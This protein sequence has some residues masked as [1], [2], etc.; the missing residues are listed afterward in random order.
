M[1]EGGVLQAAVG[2]DGRKLGRDRLLADRGVPVPAGDDALH[3]GAARR[4]R[5]LAGAEQDRQPHVL[6]PFVLPGEQLGHPGRRVPDVHPAPRP[7]SHQHKLAGQFGPVEGY[8]L[9]DQAA[10]G[11]GEQVGLPK[12]ECVDE[13]DRVAGHRLDAVRDQPAG[14]RHAGVVEQDDLTVGGETVGDGRVMVIERAHKVLEEH[15]RPAAGHAEPAVREPD[16]FRLDEL[17]CGGVVRELLHVSLPHRSAA[18]EAA[19]RVCLR[20]CP[21]DPPAG[22]RTMTA[23]RRAAPLGRAPDFGRPRPPLKRSHL[24]GRAVRHARS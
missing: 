3:V 7:R 1:R 6:L 17:G 23:L 11:V 21:P 5:L 24:T 16:A 18:T 15:Q 10:H 13:A 19:T 14:R 12:A 9:R 8:F 20:A 2:P 4:L 22:I